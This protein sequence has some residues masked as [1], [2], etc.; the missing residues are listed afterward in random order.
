MNIH[1]VNKVLVAT[2]S[3]NGEGFLK[4]KGTS[5]FETRKHGGTNGYKL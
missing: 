3:P 4:H 5:F 1:K 2:E